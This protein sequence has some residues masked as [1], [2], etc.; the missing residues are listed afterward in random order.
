MSFKNN[1][2]VYSNSKKFDCNWWLNVFS[3][4]NHVFSKFL[5][6]ERNISW[7]F[8]ESA[9]FSLS[10][11]EYSSQ[12]S[13]MMKIQILTGNEKLCKVY[14]KNY[15]FKMF[16]FLLTFFIDIITTVISFT[17]I[18]CDVMCVQHIIQWFLHSLQKFFFL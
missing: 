11:K 8:G 15:F 6:F 4:K 12:Y 1:I 2:F 16:K 18:A 3:V 10:L 13:I 7:N 5:Y 14:L 9:T 17:H